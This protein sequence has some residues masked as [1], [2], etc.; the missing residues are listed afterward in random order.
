MSLFNL[1]WHTNTYIGNNKGICA[2]EILQLVLLTLTKEES[3]GGSRQIDACNK[4][5]IS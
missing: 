4:V 3:E 1:A 2:S 5:S